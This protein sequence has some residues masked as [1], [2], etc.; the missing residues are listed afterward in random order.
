MC[1]LSGSSI[2][3]LKAAEF[4]SLLAS[5]KAGGSPCGMTGPIELTADAV[6]LLIELLV[7]Y[8]LLLMAIS[9]YWTMSSERSVRNFW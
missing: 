5:R 9:I 1:P 8:A 3:P 7:S 4:S 2:P 6:V